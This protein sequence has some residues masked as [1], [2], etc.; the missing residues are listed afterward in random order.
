M[1]IKNIFIVLGIL[2]INHQLSAMLPEASPL[3]D[4][5]VQIFQYS[6]ECPDKGSIVQSLS[7]ELDAVCMLL[8]V[9]DKGLSLSVSQAAALN[10]LLDMLM[11]ALPH[12]ISDAIEIRS[13]LILLKLF[14]REKVSVKRQACDFSIFHNPNMPV[15]EPI[16]RSYSGS[17]DQP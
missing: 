5:F 14:L 15:D 1:K 13:Q 2:L 17:P 11:H 6:E 3:H 10:G 12:D 4:Q 9:V 16:D 7:C 8:K